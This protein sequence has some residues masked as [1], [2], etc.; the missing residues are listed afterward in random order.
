MIH[1]DRKPGVRL[2]T[3]HPGT[4]PTPTTGLPMSPEELRAYS[5]QELAKANG[6]CDCAPAPDAR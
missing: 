4:V 2:V 5:A 1:T 3:D 6:R